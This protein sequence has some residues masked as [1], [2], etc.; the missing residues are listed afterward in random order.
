MT[1]NQLIDRMCET[2]GMS[3]KY[4]EAAVD[5][6]MKTILET[7]KRGETIVIPGFGTFYVKER[8]ER[9]GRNL[10]TGESITIPAKKV[11]AFK[12]GKGMKEAV[13]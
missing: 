11:P 6:L 2:G 10:K 4:A 1:K 12:P 8:G 3:R 9:R 5:A 13:G 7:M